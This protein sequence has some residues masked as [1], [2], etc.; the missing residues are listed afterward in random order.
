MQYAEET[1]YF[2]LLFLEKDIK[3]EG[4][5]LNDEVALGVSKYGKPDTSSSITKC[6]YVD[7]FLQSGKGV[8]LGIYQGHNGSYVAHL[9]VHELHK[10][11][12]KNL[13]RVW[14]IDLNAGDIKAVFQEAYQ[15]MDRIQ[16]MAEG[17][18]PL[19]RWSGCSAV[20]CF[21]VGNMLYVANEGCL[22]GLLVRDN[23]TMREVTSVHNLYNQKERMRVRR[24][25]GVIVKTE[26]C[27]L[28]NGVLAT[29]RGLGNQGD[30]RLKVCVINRP[31]FRALS[32]K[33]TDKILVLASE[34]LWKVFNYSE[35]L[36]L[37]N[38]FIHEALTEKTFSESEL[39]KEFSKTGMHEGHNLLRLPKTIKH[40]S[41]YRSFVKQLNKSPV[42][43]RVP[44]NVDWRANNPQI[45]IRKASVSA[46]ESSSKNFPGT[47]SWKSDFSEGEHD[48][49]DL[50][51]LARII[52]EESESFHARREI[53]RL[54][55]KRL[56]KSA[57][58]A[59]AEMD[60]VVM[61]LLLQGFK[62]EC[63]KFKR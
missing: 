33:E 32:L 39:E 20:T 26:K 17:E 48:D 56:L 12:R 31:A 42:D 46:E 13:Q 14:D 24:N 54:L 55:S 59:G 37:L 35:I 43:F 38:K 44:Q 61:V 25:Q 6:I 58:I 49:D 53:S 16:L 45:L 28:V 22:K 1:I 40:D 47:M 60:N 63:M 9:C 5:I 27:A 4:T 30:W 11:I 15:R 29:T 21:L 57:L 19:I 3:T 23:N 62:I 2:I 36:F 51:E 50:R 52:N 7:D 10:Y 34:G 8:F 18:H 41:E